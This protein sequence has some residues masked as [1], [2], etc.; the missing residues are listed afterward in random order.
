MSP[1]SDTIRT[2]HQAA[3]RFGKQSELHAILAGK[4]LLDLRRN[5]R[6]RE[7]RAWVAN[8]R[9]PRRANYRRSTF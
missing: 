9:I 1:G 3:V 4:A 6:A 5:M 7:W 8:A 2:Q